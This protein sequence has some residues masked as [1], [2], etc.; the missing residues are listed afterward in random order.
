MSDS[1]LPKSS[2]KLAFTPDENAKIINH[3]KTTLTKNKAVAKVNDIFH[4]TGD[5]GSEH[6][7]RIV[8]VNGYPLNI[9]SST[10]YS[11][12]GFKTAGHM[13]EVFFIMNPLMKIDDYVFV[14]GF[15][16][17][18]CF[19]CA[20]DCDNYPTSRICKNW[21]NIVKEVLS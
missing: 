2:V 18:T 5:D 6:A 9:A 1:C 7:F 3:E 8:A 17:I 14:H 20:R 11:T 19:N 4:I 10:F 21:K 16:E 13:A 15:R 12:E